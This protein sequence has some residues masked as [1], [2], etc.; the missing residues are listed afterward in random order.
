MTY[1]VLKV[2]LNPNQPTN[3]RGQAIRWRHSRFRGSK[4]CCRGNHFLAFYGVYIGAAWRIWLN[5]PCAA[6]MRP[7]VKLRWP[8]VYLELNS[9][10]SMSDSLSHSG[11]FAVPPCSL[12]NISTV[13]T[14][15]YLDFRFTLEIRGHCTR[16]CTGW[17]CPC[18]LL[19]QFTLIHNNWRISVICCRYLQNRDICK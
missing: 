11:L 7:Y 16:I 15:Y 12:F 5:H 14:D 2:P 6:A 1:S 19:S 13:N 8:F 10:C 9:S 3:L 18:K 17:T 4:G